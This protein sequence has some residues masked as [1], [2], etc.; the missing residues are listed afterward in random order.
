MSLDLVEGDLDVV[1]EDVCVVD[2]GGEGVRGDHV[3]ISNKLDVVSARWQLQSGRQGVLVLA[4]AVLVQS[5]LALPVGK[6]AGDVDS[7]GGFGRPP[8]DDGG[9]FGA[10]MFGG[11]ALEVVGFFIV[12]DGAADDTAAPGEIIG[13]VVDVEGGG[14]GGAWGVDF[15]LDWQRQT[16]RARVTAGR[17]VVC[18]VERLGGIDG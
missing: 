8:L 10:G 1:D 4:R 15:F 17:Q 18:I 16:G 5:E 12:V 2:G 6:G 7:I 11:V 3:P 14:Y 13:L 9:H